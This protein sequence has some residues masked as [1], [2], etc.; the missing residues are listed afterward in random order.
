MGSNVSVGILA[1]TART[2]TTNS[3]D[4]VNY[5]CRGL[6][7]VVDV[8]SVPSIDTVTPKIQGIANGVYY[9]ILVG[10]PI[11]ATGIT[12]LKVYPGIAAIANA[13]ANDILPL[14]WRVVMTHSAGTSFTYSVSANLEE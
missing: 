2:S 6:H 3:A 12:V 8:T 7:L 1:A 5:N 14:H 11:S 13:S 9:D 4:Q 10:S